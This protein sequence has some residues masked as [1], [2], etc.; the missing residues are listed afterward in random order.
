MGS[1]ISMETIIQVYEELWERQR[2]LTPPPLVGK[3][4]WYWRHRW[5]SKGLGTKMP[6]IHCCDKKEHADVACLEDVQ[7]LF[8]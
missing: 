7:S 1:S 4:S 3:H 2:D 8:A 5:K 6:K